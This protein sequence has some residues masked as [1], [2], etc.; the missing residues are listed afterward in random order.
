MPTRPLSGQVS[1]APDVRCPHCGSANIQEDRLSYERYRRRN[2]R[3]CPD[4]HTELRSDG[5][6][7]QCTNLFRVIYKP[8]RVLKTF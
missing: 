3:R 1:S 4:R 7:F 6:C 2:S 8:V 5:W